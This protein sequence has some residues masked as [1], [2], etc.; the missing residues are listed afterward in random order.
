MMTY[1]FG[2]LTYPYTRCLA[3]TSC[4]WTRTHGSDTTQTGGNGIYTVRVEFS[5]VK[6]GTEEF[7]VTQPFSVPEFGAPFVAVSAVGFASIALLVKI[8]KR[9]PT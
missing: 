9:T 1:T 8:R 5:H 7:K 6:G 3:P 2:G 4:G